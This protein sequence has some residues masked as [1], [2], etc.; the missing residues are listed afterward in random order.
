MIAI[1]FG[2]VLMSTLAAVLFT[3]IA[4]AYSPEQQQ[5]C[6][7]DAMRLCGSELPNIERITACMIAKR[8]ALSPGCRVYFRSSAPSARG[9]QV[10]MAPV[11]AHRRVSI[12]AKK[13]R[14]QAGP[15]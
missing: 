11:A 6:S 7:G 10:R 8:S 5:A 9:R 2:L 3:G 1:R 4:H 15:R 12:K 14:K 13:L